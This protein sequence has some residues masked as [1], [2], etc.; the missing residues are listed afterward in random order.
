MHLWPGLGHSCHV[1]EGWAPGQ[2]EPSLAEKALGM[3]QAITW[4][5]HSS[6]GMAAGTSP[7]LGALCTA[8]ISSV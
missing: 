3:S 5:S 2:G 4:E 7:P 1:A 6:E 8:L